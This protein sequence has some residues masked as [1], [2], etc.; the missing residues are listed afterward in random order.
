MENIP[1]LVKERLLIALSNQLARAI[2]DH[3][4][5]IICTWA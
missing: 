1:F 3:S 5:L 2:V 4:L